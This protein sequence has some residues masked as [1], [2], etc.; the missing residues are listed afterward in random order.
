M[1]SQLFLEAVA[2][3]MEE[4]GGGRHGD[5]RRR[6]EAGACRTGVNSMGDRSLQTSG[7]TFS[8]LV[9][10]VWEQTIWHLPSMYVAFFM[11]GDPGLQV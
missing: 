4:V 10:Y 5:G 6:W 3:S 8:L 7:R 11:G 1:S 9:V 2:G